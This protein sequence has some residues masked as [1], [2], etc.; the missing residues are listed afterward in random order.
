MI[1]P[2]AV[3]R[4]LVGEVIRRFEEKG[5]KIIGMRFLHMSEEQAKKLYSVHEGK[6]FFDSL[7]NYITSG[8]VVVMVLESKDVINVVRT[9]VGATNPVDASPGTI[10]GDYGLDIGRNIVHASDAEKTADYEIPIFFDDLK[11]Y[12]RI[13][14]KWLYE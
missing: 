14:E 2:D 4:G 13:D 10:R 9:L 5:L 3:Q 6:K 1:K 11:D 12:D 8:P 7:I